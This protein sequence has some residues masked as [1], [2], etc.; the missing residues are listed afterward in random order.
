ME[1]DDLF[2]LP[3]GEFTAARN[4]LVKELRAAGERD[5]A[6]AVAELR[7]PTAA[8]W[9]LNQVARRAPDLI[10]AVLDAGQALVREQRRALSGVDAAD[11]RG[12]A[13]DRRA[14]IEAA[15]AAAEAHL[16][17]EGGAP[18]TH[19]DR[20]TATLEAASL[21]PEAAE[22]VRA[23]RLERELP[24]P[25]G[26]GDP[27]GLTLV[28]G[29][30][31]AGEEG[32]APPPELPED[33]SPAQHAAARAA[34]EAASARSRA[35]EARERADAAR[36][37]RERARMVAADAEGALD[38]ARE[39]VNAAERALGEAR[40]ALERAEDRQTDAGRGLDRATEAA[41]EAAEAAAVA[42]GE[43]DDLVEDARRAA[44][45]AE[46]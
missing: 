46:G 39:Q 32:A 27:G 45:R 24:A 22:L 15:R 14:A 29:G 35:Q 19:R 7:R 26:L 40:A 10:A 36:A 31:P 34:A 23:G 9:A 20:I 28:S 43:A 5:A 2:D 12:A 38:R 16:T 44:R 13:A 37:E 8:A 25:T 33:A 1:A 42:E 11:L 3:P 41:A 21:Q 30:L 6:A 17:G 4:R 18:A